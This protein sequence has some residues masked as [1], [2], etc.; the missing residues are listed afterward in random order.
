MVVTLVA[1]YEGNHFLSCLFFAFEYATVYFAA[2]RHL[3]FTE[4]YSFWKMKK[5]MATRHR[6]TQQYIIILKILL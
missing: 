3:G 4:T 1:V 2:T 6:R 5:Q